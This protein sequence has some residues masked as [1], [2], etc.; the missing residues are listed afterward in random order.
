M[1]NLNFPIDLVHIMKWL[2][3]RPLLQG[4]NLDYRIHLLSV[5]SL[6]C[7]STYTHRTNWGADRLWWSLWHGWQG[8]FSSLCLHR[9]YLY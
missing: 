6:V 9:L 3:R 7:V 8:Q 5:N 1:A 4:G 2:R